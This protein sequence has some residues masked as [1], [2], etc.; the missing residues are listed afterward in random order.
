MQSVVASVACLEMC[1][2]VSTF[3]RLYVFS[4][5]YLKKW[6]GYGHRTWQ[7]WFAMSPGKNHLFWDEKVNDQGHEA[8]KTANVDHDA[9]VSA[10][11]F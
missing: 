6:F 7:S 5:R 2:Y 10:G 9:F 8:Q 4:T 1:L 3:V 11:F